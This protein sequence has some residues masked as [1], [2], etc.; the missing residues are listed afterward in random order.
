[1]FPWWWWFDF[2]TRTLMEVQ[3]MWLGAAIDLTAR[4]QGHGSGLQ[5]A[6]ACPLCALPMQRVRLQATGLLYQR[7]SDCGLIRIAEAPARRVLRSPPR[8]TPQAGSSSSGSDG[9]PRGVQ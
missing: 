9:R 6:A 7:C 3:R 4:F 5:R 8:R 2:S 1:M